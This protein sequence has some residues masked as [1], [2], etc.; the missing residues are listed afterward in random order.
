ML[1]VRPDFALQRIEQGGQHHQE[2]QHLDAEAVAFIEF[3]LRGPVQEGGDVLGFLVQGRL[4]AV[5]IGHD[6]VRERGRHADIMAGERLVVAHAVRHHGGI[7]RSI[8][9][10]G[11]H[12]IDIVRTALARL[13]QQR[14]VGRQGTVIGRARR[15]WSR[16]STKAR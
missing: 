7:R 10:A 8:H 12:R 9:I 3:R 6:I 14:L 13:D 1:D 11:Q 16:I 4:G 15:L 5:G 2:A